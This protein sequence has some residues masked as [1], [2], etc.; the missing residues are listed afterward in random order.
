MEIPYPRW[1]PAIALRRSRRRYLTSPIP[2]QSLSAL[3]QI[4]LGFR[5]FPEARVELV[6][7]SVDEIFKGILGSYGKVVGAPAFLAFIGDIQSPAVQESVGYTGEGIILEAVSQGFSTCWV[8]GMFRPEV[9]ARVAGISPSEKVLAVSPI[10]FASL[11]S[12][13]A[14]KMLTGFGRAHKRKPLSDLVSGLP[15]KD[16][17]DWIK[18]A[19]QAARLAPSAYNR[20]PWRFEVD[21]DSIVISVD[22]THDIGPSRRLESGMAM[23]HIELG[24]LEKGRQGKWKTLESP[25]VARFTV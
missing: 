23:L 16:W 25:R 13:F 5:P 24:A 11:T 15:E 10:G 20:Q 17:P 18:I 12:P 14:E 19:L 2:D 6:V 3:R 9:A 4:C 21:S 1:Y 22:R 7:G 8:T